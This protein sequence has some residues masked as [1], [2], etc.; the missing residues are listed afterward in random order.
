MMINAMKVTKRAC[1]EDQQ[2][3]MGEEVVGNLHRWI[4]RKSTYGGT[5]SLRCERLF[6]KLKG[7]QGGQST[8]NKG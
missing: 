5:F 4:L 7:G 8:M 6:E 2:S 1:N 3:G